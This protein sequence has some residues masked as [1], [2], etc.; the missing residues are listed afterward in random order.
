MAV[1]VLEDSAVTSPTEQVLVDELRKTIAGW[2]T[3]RYTGY[4]PPED[5]DAAS[6]ATD[7]VRDCADQLEL[8]LKR[9]GYDSPGS[10]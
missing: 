2:K 10:I 1:E 5:G 3:Y 6:Y 9:L 7:E 4:V 8:M